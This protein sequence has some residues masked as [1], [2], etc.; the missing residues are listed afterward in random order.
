MLT[1]NTN[2]H[3]D[4]AS[5]KRYGPETLRHYLLTFAARHGIDSPGVRMEICDL[6]RDLDAT[7]DALAARIAQAEQQIAALLAASRPAD[8]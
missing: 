3:G 6:C 2:E 1:L 4:K 5:A 8:S 7:F